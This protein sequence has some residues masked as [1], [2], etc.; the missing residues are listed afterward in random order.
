MPRKIFVAAALAAALVGCS[1]G[2]GGASGSGGDH[3][4][5]PGTVAAKNAAG[6]AALEAALASGSTDGYLSAIDQFTA[7]QA[8]AASDPAATA[9]DLDRAAFFG[10]L[11]RIAILA[12][13]R[14]DGVADGLQDLGDLLDGFGVRTGPGERD[15]FDA[16]LVQTCTMSW[17]GVMGQYGYWSEDCSL[18]P[19]GP[20]SPRSGEVQVFLVNRVAARLRDAIAILGGVSPSFQAFL[21]VSGRSVELDHTDALFMRA[22]AQAALAVIEAQDAYDLDADIDDVRAKL[23][24]V[25]PYGYGDFLAEYPSFL[26]LVRAAALP[27]SRADALVAVRTGRAA[28]EALRRETDAQGDDLIRIADEHCTYDYVNHAITCATTYNP[29]GIV[30]DYTQFL[31]TVEAV[32]AASAT[33]TLPQGPTAADDLV[34][35]PSR[36]F[37]G[38]DLRALL[39]A[40]Y[41]AG[42]SGDRPGAFPDVTFGGLLVSGPWNVNQDLDG[43]GC[44]DFLFGY[45]YYGPW[46]HGSSLHTSGPY[47]GGWFTFAQAGNTFSLW[48]YAQGVTA[49]GTWSYATNHLTLTFDALQSGGMKSMEITTTDMQRDGTFHGTVEYRDGS[50]ARLSTVLQGIAVAG[51]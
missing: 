27:Q 41:T 36:F 9:N 20:N 18:L 44:P 49:T 14:S 25:A 3:G 40:T 50:G 26:R 7:A 28:L 45:S 19:I 37:G 2:G 32:L 5:T 47:G 8:A 38:L 10:A 42:A 48:M 12:S 33:Y 35:D 43:D 22:F 31:A 30:D 46:L 6:S 15:V 17:V 34:L 51:W 4:V 11:A 13:P 16:S 29:A 24:A 1:G 23:E 21:Q 39:P